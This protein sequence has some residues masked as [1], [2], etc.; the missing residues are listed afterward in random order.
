MHCACLS[1]FLGLPQELRT[2]S[3]INEGQAGRQAVSTPSTPPGQRKAA[4]TISVLTGTLATKVSSSKSHAAKTVAAP[5][6][7]CTVEKLH[8]SPR[9]PYAPQVSLC[10][11]DLSFVSVIYLFYLSSSPLAI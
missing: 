8:L 6:S 5:P 3:G 11:P 4:K 2:E 7:S 1:L 9:P 10:L